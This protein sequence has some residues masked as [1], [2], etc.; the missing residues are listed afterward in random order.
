MADEI[1]LPDRR[2]FASAWFGQRQVEGAIVPR[3]RM[4]TAACRSGGLLAER[5]EGT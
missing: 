3:G 5:V 1:T 4:L 2:Y